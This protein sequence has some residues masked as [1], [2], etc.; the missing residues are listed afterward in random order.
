MDLS[1]IPAVPTYVLVL[2]FSNLISL[3]V[4]A[5]VYPLKSEDREGVWQDCLTSLPK[6]ALYGSPCEASLSVTHTH[7]HV[8]TYACTPACST[9]TA[10]N[11]D[12]Q[13][14]MFLIVEVC[15]VCVC[16]CV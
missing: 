7:T 8:C 9:H 11:V 16:V 3:S 6:H 14:S 13:S 12:L 15:C 1:R 4:L 5:V 2:Q 10:A